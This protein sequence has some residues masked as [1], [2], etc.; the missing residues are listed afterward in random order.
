MS[1]LISRSALLEELR[2]LADKNSEKTQC[3]VA[4]IGAIIKVKDAPT[5]YDVEE[6]AKQV[7]NIILEEVNNVLKAIPEGAEY[8]EEAYRLLY[9]DT[10]IRDV[11]NIVRKGG[12]SND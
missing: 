7:H 1:D 6:I 10:K 11:I 5:A 8:T 9:L 3:Y 2:A 12:V 4:L